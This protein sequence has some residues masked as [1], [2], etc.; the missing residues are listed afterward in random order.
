MNRFFVFA[1]GRRI[2]P[3]PPTSVPDVYPFYS[4]DIADTAEPIR[5]PRIDLYSPD[6]FVPHRPK[7]PSSSSPAQ[8]SSS[9]FSRAPSFSLSSIYSHSARKRRD[10]KEAKENRDRG[11][12]SR[13]DRRF[14][15]SQ[16]GSTAENT[17]PD[18]T[19][20]TPWQTSL[21]VREGT[22]SDGLVFQFRKN[23]AAE[24]PVSE[25]SGGEKNYF[26]ASQ[27]E[28][29]TRAHNSEDV[30]TRPG[31]QALLRF[32]RVTFGSKAEVFTERLMNKKIGTNTSF[33][34]TIHQGSEEIDLECI[35]RDIG[36]G[37]VYRVGRKLEGGSWCNL[38]LGDKFTVRGGKR[39]RHELT[40][41]R[42]SCTCI[43]CCLRDSEALQE[44]ESREPPEKTLDVVSVSSVSAR[45]PVHSAMANFVVTY[46]LPSSQDLAMIGGVSSWRELEIGS[47]IRL[48]SRPAAKLKFTDDVRQL[49]GHLAYT[50]PVGHE[51]IYRVVT[52]IGVDYYLYNKGKKER[53]VYIQGDLV[54]LPI[55]VG[56]VKLGTQPLYMD[57][58]GATFVLYRSQIMSIYVGEI[59]LEGNSIGSFIKTGIRYYIGFG[60]ERG[61]CCV[62]PDKKTGPQRKLGINELLL[63]H[64]MVSDL[65]VRVL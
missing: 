13:R 11:G 4:T 50:G 62:Y 57:D 32:L 1:S 28:E 46:S 38:L 18:T 42:E 41:I 26:G 30:G 3:S 15:L 47:I 34:Y 37:R 25:V 58:L 53:K 21:P 54:R 9:V 45:T 36:N 60:E 56:V 14:A 22:E 7:S 44:S 43:R 63:H 55:N 8:D 2:P 61:A 35:S 64:H 59:V 19:D 31:E 29:Y 23:R 16:V 51:E 10:R 6:T 52:T 65:A 20:S 12:L 5:D 40:Y 49:F 27:F 24:T 33:E 48:N 39:Q 17:N